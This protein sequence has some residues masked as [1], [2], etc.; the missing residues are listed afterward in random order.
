VFPWLEYVTPSSDTYT[1]VPYGPIDRVASGPSEV[2]YRAG[3]RLRRTLRHD[4]RVE[5]EVTL[6]RVHGFE[7]EPAARRTNAFVTG[8]LTW[9]PN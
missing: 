4:L 2:R 6:E 3:C 5:S 7:F 1:F 8:A 9:T